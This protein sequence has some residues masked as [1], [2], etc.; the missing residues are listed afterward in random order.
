MKEEPY[1]KLETSKSL[2]PVGT[3]VKLV[4]EVVR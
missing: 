4:L 3:P 2:P 1:L